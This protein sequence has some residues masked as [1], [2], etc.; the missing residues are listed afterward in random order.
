MIKLFTYK[1]FKEKIFYVILFVTLF[2]FSILYYTLYNLRLF[3]DFQFFLI[4]ILVIIFILITFFFYRV[5]KQIYTLFFQT[6]F[7][8]AGYQ[9]HQRLALLFSAVCLMPSIIISTFSIITLNTALDGWF[10]NKISTAVSQSVEVANKYLTEH[11]N[12]MKGKILDF[13]N[14]LNVNAVRF[15]SNE[16]KINDFLNFYVIKNNFA[17]A[18]LIDSTRNILAHSKYSFEINYLDISDKFFNI[19]NNGNIVLTNDEDTNKVKA[20][21]KLNQFVDAYL[22]V[23]RFLD[24][25]VLNA[26]NMT[27]LAA[28]DYQKIELNKFDIKISFLA[29]F[30]LISFLL[31]LISLYV[32]LGLAN[33]LISPIGELI[34]AAEEVGR[35]NL[36][37]KIKNQSLIKNKVKELKRLGNAFN[38]M[39][40]DIKNS[41]TE[42]IDANDQIDKR[43][44]FSEAV[45]SG[46]YSGVIGLDENLKI[47]LPNLTAKN[48]LNISVET[49]FNKYLFDVLPE[50]K[51]LL[52]KI[53]LNTNTFVED[54]IELFRDEKK[55]IL[56]ARIVKQLKENRVL[57]YVVT[58]E[59]V[60]DLINAQKLAAWSDVARKIAHEIKNP[61]TPI[62]LGAE[63][64][65]NFNFKYSSDKN[66]YN[67]I[68][69]MILRQVDDIHHLIDEFSSFA[70]MPSP[71]L[72]KINLFIILKSYLDPIENFFPNVKFIF[73]DNKVS[74]VSV[75]ADEKQLRQVFG[76][77]IKNSY[78]NF[79]EHKLINP[80]IEVS[81]NK[82]AKFCRIFIKD[83]GTG[84]KN[85][86]KE[87]LMEPYY[88]NKINGTGL[89]LA[90]SKKIMEDHNGSINVQSSN[91]GT[92]VTLSLPL[93]K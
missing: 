68:V 20:F 91:K 53:K 8:I 23:S 89:G 59:D 37:F 25:K 83:N 4:A 28:L 76:N 88:T 13:A 42:L 16:E 72:K 31:L 84:I 18:V 40:L 86:L 74:F 79:K 2:F 54:K 38:K 90:I 75:L 39:I 65:K 80:I 71:K 11:K 21:I 46:V 50:F 92:L 26:I 27:S 52:N 3:K 45:L 70:R 44:Q 41:R 58:F 73:N 82:E 30:V 24:Q 85:L 63:R 47:N 34:F 93:V 35:G 57:G 33:R 60:T 19:A 10:N 61:L 7:K 32:G 43:R 5:S 55:L 64:L 69:D 29:L 77:I 67:Q 62:K 66:K 1:L 14:Q 51:K 48:L 12:T 17:D 56:I 15:S 6:K 22:L 81:I 87:R 49:H 9:L 78:E 36:N